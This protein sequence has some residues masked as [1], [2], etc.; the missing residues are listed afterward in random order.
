V[1]KS[2]KLERSR[3]LE[4][5][6]KDM[7]DIDFIE[8]DDF[9]VAEEMEKEQQCCDCL[10]VDL[11]EEGKFTKKS[12]SEDQPQHLGQFSPILLKSYR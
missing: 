10:A 4:N 11:I 1:P 12:D 9:F 3:I 2:I 5:H 6:Y 7:Q 8:N